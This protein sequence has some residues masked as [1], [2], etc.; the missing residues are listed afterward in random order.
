[1]AMPFSLSS[2]CMAAMAKLTVSVVSIAPVCRNWRT[3]LVMER[4]TVVLIL[5]FFGMLLSS[6]ML[7][8]C[9]VE[10]FFEFF[11]ACVL[12]IVQLFIQ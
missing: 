6:F 7:L 2:R 1:M 5:R 8:Q 12:D 9:L 4:L 10:F 11:Y 3:I